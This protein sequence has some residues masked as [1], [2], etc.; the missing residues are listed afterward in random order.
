MEACTHSARSPFLGS[1]AGASA[2]ASAIVG[3]DATGAF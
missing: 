2:A 1:L 3:A